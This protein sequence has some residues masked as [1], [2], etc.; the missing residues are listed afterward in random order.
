MT[1]IEIARSIKMLEISEI[2]KKIGIGDKY[3]ENYG[4]YKAKIDLGILNELNKK[5]GKLILVTSINPTPFGE[6]KTTMSIGIHDALR[7]LGFNSLAVLREPSLGP[8]FGIKGGA[9]GGGYSQVVPME[10]IN[11]HFTGDMHAIGAANNLLCAAIDNHIF[12]GNKLNIDKNKIIFNRCVDMNDRALRTVTVG[13]DLG[14]DVIHE[15][16][17]SITV[18]TEVMAILCLAENLK[19]LKDR[20]GNILFAYDVDGKPLFVRDLHVEEAM[21]ILLKDAI[22]PNL[23]QTLENNPVIIHG[24]PFA[25]I[26]HGCNSLIATKLGLKLSDYV[27]T[28][29]GFGADLGAEKFLDIKCRKGNLKP[30]VIVINATIRSL[31]YNGG[32]SKDELN[33]KNMEYL[34]KGI[35]NLEVHIENMKKYL[36]NIVVCLN[37]FDFDDEDEI[38]FVENYCEKLGCE[39]AVCTSYKDGGEGATD[40]ARK[41]V[42]LCENDIE[43]NL[44]YDENDSI[45]NKIEKVSKDIYHAGS[46]K[47]LDEAL[48]NIQKIESMGLDKLPI[49][50]AKTQYSISDDAKKLG[51]P[52]DYEI[53][54][55]DVL[56]NSGAGFIVVYMGKIMTM[57]GLSKNPAYENMHIDDDGT[58]YGLF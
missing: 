27:V 54:V 37:K 38:S 10:D 4:K 9:A 44:L 22:K 57:P 12:Q 21:T 42:K 30:S 55:R 23:V 1:D 28:E 6:G 24:G 5:E 58:I 18:A 47:Y 45:K 19:D 56:I 46:V 20:L 35:C 52:K 14:K 32:M 16:H 7:K 36:D 26:A 2:A 15:N 50:V 29:A 34:K 3:L 13:L 49:C 31:K 17:Y 41:I 33:I 39:F 43:F 53:I 8:V 48:E 51:Y 25:N 40:L 11:L